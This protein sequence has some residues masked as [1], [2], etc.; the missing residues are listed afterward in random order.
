[1]ATYMYLFN[2][3]GRL[4]L[5][6]DQ[7]SPNT[8][9]SQAYCHTEHS[10]LARGVTFCMKLT[11]FSKMTGCNLRYAHNLVITVLADY[12]ARRSVRPTAGT[13]LTI[14]LELIMVTSS[15]GNIFRVTGHMCEEFTGHRFHLD[16]SIVLEVTHTN[17]SRTWNRN[18][19]AWLPIHVVTLHKIF[20]V[21]VSIFVCWTSNEFYPVK[22]T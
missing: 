3:F 4:W 22:P 16:V 7:Y 6:Y 10:C 11:N 5:L 14:G 17:K 21:N 18:L 15:N 9:S 20:A 2:T 1:M 12:L 19:I 8:Q 13:V